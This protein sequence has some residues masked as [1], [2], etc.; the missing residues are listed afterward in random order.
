M[1]H[2][3]VRRGYSI[4]FRKRSQLKLT[5]VFMIII[6]AVSAMM[7]G[8]TA[9]K[10]H[11]DEGP[12]TCLVSIQRS[13]AAEGAVTF[14]LT[15]AN[16]SAGALDLGR[17]GNPAFRFSVVTNSGALVWESTGSEPVQQI[18]ELRTLAPSDSMVFTCT[19][20]RTD[21]RGHTVPAGEYLVH[22]RVELDPP[23]TA[24]ATP[25]LLVLD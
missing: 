8:C 18:L 23:L 22:G 16:R 14:R 13:S 6:A 25:V 1:E 7:G 15:L 19:W 21:T 9:G 24:R 2:M 11:T 20:N 10:K 4:V 12:L 3:L 5:S 17:Q